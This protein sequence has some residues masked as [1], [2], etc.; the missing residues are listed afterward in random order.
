MQPQLDL[1]LGYKFAIDTTIIALVLSLS[2]KYRIC[3]IQNSFVNVIDSSVRLRDGQTELRDPW[4]IAR[5]LK[6]VVWVTTALGIRSD[7]SA[8]KFAQS[9]NWR[10]LY[11][12]PFAGWLQALKTVCRNQSKTRLHFCRTKQDSR[13]YNFHQKWVKC[14]DGSIR[15]PNIFL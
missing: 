1:A 14:T 11:S 8:R 9:F 4:Y 3:M 10:L 13:N 15:V 6:W 7:A 12:S 5:L 2:C